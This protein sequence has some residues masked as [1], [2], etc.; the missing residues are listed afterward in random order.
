LR[1][2][3][4]SRPRPAA[5]GNHSGRGAVTYPMIDSM[6]IVVQRVRLR[7]DDRLLQVHPPATIVSIPRRN[8]RPPAIRLAPGQWL[9][10]QVNY[11]FAGGGDGGPWSYQLDTFNISY[12]PTSPGV[13]LATPPTRR[14]AERGFLR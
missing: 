13:F 10:W 4:D 5:H 3:Q 1:A 9:Q 6:D 8:R 7:E 14:V 11:R 2:W 12:G